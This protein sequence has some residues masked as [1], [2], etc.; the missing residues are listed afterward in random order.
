MFRTKCV[1]GNERV[2]DSYC[3]EGLSLGALFT[4]GG[5]FGPLASSRSTLRRHSAL[6]LVVVASGVL[7]I[8]P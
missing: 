3:P 2:Q 7:G 4:L 8:L 1:T 6:A 5:L